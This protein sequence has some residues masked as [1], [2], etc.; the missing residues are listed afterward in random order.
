MRDCKTKIILNFDA[1]DFS[2]AQIDE[3]GFIEGAAGV[4]FKVSTP[5]FCAESFSLLLNT[6]QKLES[7]LNDK[8]PIVTR[9]LFLET[10][11]TL[12][13]M[14]TRSALKVMEEDILTLGSYLSSEMVPC[15][16]F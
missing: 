10:D 2:L 1:N 7:F 15:F 4:S 5:Q 3:L 14:T 8:F 6:L 13:P 11:G 16:K 12:D 9:L